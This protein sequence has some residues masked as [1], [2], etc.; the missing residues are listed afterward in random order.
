MKNI[1]VINGIGLRA[2]ALRPLVDGTSA[3]SRALE[4]GRGLPGVQ[5]VVVLLSE[6]RDVPAGVPGGLT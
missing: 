2:P 4:F 5:D 3:F 6:P 1:A